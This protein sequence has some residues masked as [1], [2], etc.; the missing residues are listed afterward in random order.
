[1]SGYPTYNM[2]SEDENQNQTGNQGQNPDQYQDQNIPI[3]GN[4]WDSNWANAGS[5]EPGQPYFRQNADPIP[6]SPQPPIP[7]AQQRNWGPPTQ[8]SQDIPQVSHEILNQIFNQDYPNAQARAQGWGWVLGQLRD[9]AQEHKNLAMGSSNYDSS[10]DASNLFSSGNLGAAGLDPN[11]TGNGVNLGAGPASL[12]SQQH[13]PYLIAGHPNV[14]NAHPAPP[15]PPNFQA[16]FAGPPTGGNKKRGRAAS[17]NAT[18][19]APKRTRNLPPNASRDEGDNA[20]SSGIP[21]SNPNTASTPSIQ[22][23]R[24]RKRKADIDE[25]EHDGEDDHL[26]DL[27]PQKKSRGEPAASKKIGNSRKKEDNERVVEGTICDFCSQHPQIHTANP[28]DWEQVPNSNG[29]EMYNIECTNCANYRS[30]N[31]DNTELAEKGGHKCQVPG[32]VTPLIHFEHKRYGVGDPQTYEDK[33]CDSCGRKEYGETCDVDTILGYHCLNCRKAGACRVGRSTMPLRRPNKLTRRP[34]YRH[35]CDRCFLRHKEFGEL[36]G[37]D[38]CSWITDRGE[39]EENRACR[40]CKRDGAK[41]LDLGTPMDS[42]SQLDKNF[43]VSWE[44]RP[45]FE[46]DKEKTKGDRSKK[47]KWHEYAEVLP[48][49][50]W[51]KPCQGCQTAGKATDCLVMWFQ[52]NHACERCTQFGID[53]MVPENGVLRVYPIFDLSRVGFGQ[54]TPFHVCKPCAE[55]GRNC[56]RQRPCDSCRHHN[57]DCDAMNWE[58]PGCISRAKLT[59]K[60]NKTSYSPGPLYYL[61]LGYG[62]GGVNDFKDGRSLEHWIGPAAPVYGLIDP[63]DGPRRYQDVARVHKNHRPPAGVAPPG[64]P[65]DGLLS[66]MTAPELGNLIAGRWPYGYQL[67]RDNLEGYQKVWALL[68]KDQDVRMSMLNMS[69]NLSEHVTTARSFQGGPVLEDIEKMQYSMLPSAHRYPNDTQSQ[70]FSQSLTTQLPTQYGNGYNPQQNALAPQTQLYQHPAGVDQPGGFTELLN[71]S[72]EHP[73]ALGQEEYGGYDR[74]QLD[75]HS[76]PMQ[77]SLGPADQQIYG[78]PERQEERQ[79]PQDQIVPNQQ[80]WGNLNQRQLNAP[81]Q[82]MVSPQDPAVPEQDSQSWDN[83][84]QGELELLQRFMQQNAD[85]GSD[86]RRSFANSA[87]LAPGIKN[88]QQEPHSGSQAP[89]QSPEGS[90]KSQDAFPEEF[91]DMYTNIND[92]S[93]HRRSRANQEKRWHKPQTSRGSKKASLERT[94]RRNRA[95]KNANDQDVFNPF[96]GFTFGP[97]QKPQF[98]KMPKSSRWKVFNH[99]EGIDMSE[100]HESKFKEPEEESQP[101]LFS[102]VNGQTKQPTPLRD[103]LGDVPHEQKGKRTTRYCAE[104]GEGGWG[105]CGSFDPDAQGQATCQSSAHRNTVLPYFPVCDDCT[106][107]NVKYLFQHEHNPITEGE[108]L[109][110]RAYLCNECAG[111]MSS[112]APNAVQNQIV[113]TRRVYGI[114]AD[115]AHSQGIQKLPSQAANLMR[116][117]EALTGCSCANRML[118]TSLCRFHRLYYAEEVLKHAALMQ[119]WRLSRFKK[120]VCPSCLAQ[121]P[122]EQV[123][124]SAN[125]DGFVKGEPTAWACVVCSDWV[126][127]EQNDVNNQPKA[128]DKPLWNL[129]IGRKLLDPRRQITTGRVLGEV[130]GGIPEFGVSET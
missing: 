30:Q 84:D 26:S 73:A 82:Q 46:A 121:K 103:V 21:G 68:R 28:C 52:P 109:S 9:L 102:I 112:G 49:T 129:N 8:P 119:E 51:R 5:I 44:I 105:F 33:H 127:N 62:S 36:K 27:R 93:A 89:D 107:G 29:P 64:I 88:D 45:Q 17:P 25:E 124:V 126:V 91:W 95:P 20:N 58:K 60:T 10:L 23:Q 118:G 75:L 72:D 80:D 19:P 55:A 113:G 96:L 63:K 79:I 56:D 6:W 66:N 98:K 69:P 122:S 3:Q 14:V 85:D 2:S 117:T 87:I 116:N 42:F 71:E 94:A 31:K 100:W 97:D 120:A 99:L 18:A 12:Q 53:C 128:I 35:P 108:L 76:E 106:R 50:I 115:E 81:S 57:A 77:P 61:A 15:A 7:L 34:W 86:E 111:Q 13:E 1:M 130:G 37:D 24:T 22:P 74:L 48:K 11:N 54:F 104:P 67:P 16:S 78:S 65:R 123:N 59:G 114:A 40:Q 39:W 4:Q 90:N 110:M 92:K 125:V 83:Q 41:C 101:R 70:G 47:E 43:P 38:C 32:P